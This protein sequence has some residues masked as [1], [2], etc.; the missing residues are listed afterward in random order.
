[1][2]KLNLQSFTT[3]LADSIFQVN[4][5]LFY[6]VKELSLR[7]GHTIRA[8]IEG[9]RK[10]H[11]KPIAYALLL[12]TVYF[13]IARIF[14]STTLL[15][16][17]VTG[18][19]NRVEEEKLAVEFPIL[20]WFANNYAYAT[21]LLI[22]IFSL[23]SFISFLGLKANY[24]E[25]VV[26]NAYVTGHQA[27]IYAVFALV[28]PYFNDN[29]INVLLAVTISVTFNFW[30]YLQFF[31]GSNKVLLVLR[32]ILSYGLYYFIISL[33]LAVFMLVDLLF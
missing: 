12:S 28:S 2:N 5:G 16:D 27:I 23:A 19:S 1:M 14:D 22:P 26:I 7:P 29:D 32:F 24:L 17:F 6:T 11:F 18:A 13:L 4:K 3:E 10:N 9:K 20:E 15:D 21:L 31:K 8:F 25:H 30:T 33:L